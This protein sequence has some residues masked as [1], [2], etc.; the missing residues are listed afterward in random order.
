MRLAVIFKSRLGA[1]RQYAEWIKEEIGASLFSIPKITP[2]VFEDHDT[3]VIAS[4]TY[5]GWMP[6]VAFLKRNWS[7][8]KD[9]KVIIMAVGLVPPEHKW[10]QMSYQKIP[11]HIRDKVKYFKLPGKKDE[12]DMPVKKESLQPLFDELKGE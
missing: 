2:D 5:I 9:K 1:T 8:L 11:K 4:G 6:L 3:F 10:S 7:I 12:G